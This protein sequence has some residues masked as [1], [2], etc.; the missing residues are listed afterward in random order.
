MYESVSVS[1]SL[2]V[3]V[4]VCVCLC[5]C[6]CVCL[7]VWIGSF[8]GHSSGH[9][10][11]SGTQFTCFTSTKVQILTPAS[12][13][14][15][16]SGS[17]RHTQRLWNYLL[18]YV[19]GIYLLYYVHLRQQAS[20]TATSKRASSWR[21]R[22]LLRICNSLAGTHFTCFT[23]TKVQILTHQGVHLQHAVAAGSEAIIRCPVFVLLYE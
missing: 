18:Y 9:A 4:C 15:C 19:L 17:R 12:G 10:C 7:C 16:T 14:A 3:C 8:L 2:C 1:V 20:Y 13:H 23:S 22:C 11:T 5:L 6:L 21:K